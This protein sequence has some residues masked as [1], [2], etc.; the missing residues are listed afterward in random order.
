M[1][2]ECGPCHIIATGKTLSESMHFGRSWGPCETCGVTGEC[3]S[4]CQCH[5]EWGEARAQRRITVPK[6]ETVMVPLVCANIKE[7]ESPGTHDKVEV[8]DYLLFGMR[9][10][11][12]LCAECRGWFKYYYDNA[13]AESNHG[14]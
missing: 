1:S 2:F 10:R 9:L 4:G 7:K 12:P 14:K 11:V 13:M 8:E 5:G 3:T 6:L